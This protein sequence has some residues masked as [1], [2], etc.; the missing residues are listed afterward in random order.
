MLSLSVFTL[1]SILIALANPAA[2]APIATQP[3]LTKRLIG[4]HLALAPGV[5]IGVDELKDGAKL[6]KKDCATHNA[7]SNPPFYNKW[8]IVPGNNQ[9][10]MLSGLPSGVGPFCLDSDV[11]GQPFPNA[12]IWTCYPGV[13]QQQ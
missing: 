12:K 4:A 11:A 5:C 9:V 6:S 1:T 8:D 13:P 7:A 2:T 10:V 3:A